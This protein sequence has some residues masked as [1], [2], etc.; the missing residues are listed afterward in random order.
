MLF[1][2]LTLLAAFACAP[3]IASQSEAQSSGASTAAQLPEESAPVHPTNFQ[4]LFSRS[5]F[6]HPLQALDSMLRF[7]IHWSDSLLWPFDDRHHHASHSSRKSQQQQQVASP[8]RSRHHNE[9][10]LGLD[11]FGL[12]SVGS[13]FSRSKP[14]AMDC[15][16]KQDKIVCEFE[17]AGLGKDDVSVTLQEGLLTVSGSYSKQF[18]ESEGHEGL[19]VERRLGSFSRTF[20]VPSGV[21]QDDVHAKMENGLLTLTMPRESKQNGKHKIAIEGV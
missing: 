1:K 6:M 8:R 19:V 7:P 11:T 14:P 17:L 9:D 10:W 13:P 20:S 16:E 12:L 15:F 21:Q 18:D 5:A 2:K 4:E 3:V